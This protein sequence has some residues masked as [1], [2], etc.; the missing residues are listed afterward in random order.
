MCQYSTIKSFFIDDCPTLHFG[1][2]ISYQ[3]AVHVGLHDV[4]A[5]ISLWRPHEIKIFYV[6]TNRTLVTYDGLYRLSK[7]F[8]VFH[9]LLTHG[10]IIIFTR[11][12]S[13]YHT[14]IFLNNVNRFV[15]CKT[16]WSHFFFSQSQNTVAR[17]NIKMSF[18]SGFRKRNYAEYFSAHVVCKQCTYNSYYILYC[19]CLK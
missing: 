4:C 13:V 19:I 10:E 18:S 14:K 7:S 5:D 17:F 15:T 11:R 8:A 2:R 6:R 1:D 16:V 9:S 3:S 12:F